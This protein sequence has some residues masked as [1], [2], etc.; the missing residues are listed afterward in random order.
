MNEFDEQIEAMAG[1][2][3][4]SV[5]IDTLQVSLG[6]RCNQSCTHCH[7]SSS[8]HRT[9]M[10]DWPIMELVLQA[11]DRIKPKLLDLTG[12][13][14]ELNPHFQRFVE[15]LRGSGHRV[16]VR[17]NLTLLLEPGMELLPEWMRDCEVKLVASLP[18]YREE[19]VRAQ[20]GKGIYEKSI[21]AIKRL[22]AIG[23]GVAP[24]LPLAHFCHRNRPFSRLITGASWGRGSESL[25]RTC[26]RLPT[27]RSDAFAQSYRGRTANGNT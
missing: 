1:E 12:G 26:S 8:P 20:R 9:E 3:L 15:S 6:L 14:P 23:Y 7:V 2:G 4:H 19:N 16:Q 13:A 5:E 11:A 25:S 10:M 22:N 24:G 27:F 21:A 18:C 17:T